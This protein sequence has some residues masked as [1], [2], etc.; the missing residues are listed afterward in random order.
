M[1]KLRDEWDR[2]VKPTLPDLT[3]VEKKYSEIFIGD[4][5]YARVSVNYSNGCFLRG[6]AIMFVVDIECRYEDGSCKMYALNPVFIPSDDPASKI[7]KAATSYMNIWV[8]EKDILGKVK[9]PSGKIPDNEVVCVAKASK[10][11]N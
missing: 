2:K 10:K 6:Q 9:V 4:R 8:S 5:V 11:K 1:G 3:G 7:L